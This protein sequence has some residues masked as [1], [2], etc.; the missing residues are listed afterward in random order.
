M[1][2]AQNILLR[3]L[4]DFE[5]VLSE[6]SCRLL[7]VWLKITSKHNIIHTLLLSRFQKM[8]FWRKENKFKPE[9][10]QDNMF[11]FMHSF[12]KERQ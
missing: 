3:A 8:H 10:F 5:G 6:K 7:Y 11:N 12:P 4:Q 1:L 9:K 2:V